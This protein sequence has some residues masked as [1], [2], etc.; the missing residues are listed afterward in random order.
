MPTAEVVSKLQ[1]VSGGPGIVSQ[2]WELGEI[3]VS[4]IGQGGTGGLIGNIGGDCSQSIVAFSGKLILEPSCSKCAF[5]LKL[6]AKRNLSE[7]EGK[8]EVC[9]KISRCD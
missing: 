3:A 1:V 2:P 5:F 9:G 6:H 7:R 8:S 4:R